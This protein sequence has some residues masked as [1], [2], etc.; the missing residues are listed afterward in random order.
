MDCPQCGTPCSCPDTGVLSAPA[1]GGLGWNAVA[2]R[3]YSSRIGPAMPTFLEPLTGAA[4]RI[5]PLLARVYSDS[6][7]Q[8]AKPEA[9]RM[10]SAEPFEP[11]VNPVQPIPAPPS[12]NEEWR[13]EVASRVH[14]YRARQKNSPAE[15]QRLGFPPQN[16]TSAGEPGARALPKPTE[17]AHS[18]GAEI[19]RE[20]LSHR[21]PNESL[22]GA[23]DTNYYRRLNAQEQSTQ[24]AAAK[25]FAAAEQ[26]A[27]QELE[28]GHRP[29]HTTTRELMLDLELH[30]PALGDACLDRYRIH[31]DAEPSSCA[32][33]PSAP[34]AL[35]QQANYRLGGDPEGVLG[36]RT[37]AAP[38][39]AD[40]QLDQLGGLQLDH[41]QLDGLQHDNVALRQP[42]PMNA[43]PASAAHG[44]LLVFPRPLLEPPLW[45]QPSRDELADPVSRPRILDV[46][47]EIMPTVQGSLFPEIRLDAEEP[48]L[49]AR[50]EPEI[51]IPLPVAPLS[52]R[53]KAG[54]A[55]VAVV[56]FGGGLFAAIAGRAMPELGAKPFSVVIA[57]ATVLLWAAYQQMFLLYAG[58]TLGMR[59]AGIRLSTFDGRTPRW[60][61]RRSRARYILV[62]C[63]SVTLG[64]LWALVDEDTLCWH[65]RASQTFPTTN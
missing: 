48:E 58:R 44:N 56:A 13:A 20:H 52:A 36:C 32:G 12:D 27:G 25:E 65:D 29:D 22:P 63:A 21:K 60:S 2:A 37:A 18:E 47:E 30:A 5:N 10:H 26:V 49:S 4:E 3:V 51:G 41:P 34:A 6:V 55:D 53:L 40:P 46:P 38:Q 33:V 59:L 57:V 7:A 23:F 31:D 50:R 64:F 45:A 19:S 54:L 8:H 39:T 15:Q 16:A 35:P 28:G 17:A 24:T 1:V 11:S 42:S 9:N 62:S 61:E 14:S 43:T